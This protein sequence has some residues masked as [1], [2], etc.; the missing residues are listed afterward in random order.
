MVQGC[1][2]EL[3]QGLGPWETIKRFEILERDLTVESGELT[4]SLKLKRRVVERRYG[5]LLDSLYAEPAR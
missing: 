2:D 1:V 4:P 3:N 5:D